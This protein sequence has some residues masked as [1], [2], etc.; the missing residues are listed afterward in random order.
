MR[1]VRR[2]ASPQSTDFA[3][4]KDAKPYLISRLGPYCSYCERK[5]VTMLAVEHLQPKG[6]ASY[7]H[8]EG[9]WEN[10]LLA[11]VNCNSKKRSKNV[12]FAQ[13]FF[14]DRDNTFLA[15]TYL[16][17]GTIEP[18]AQAC[19]FGQKSIADATLSLTGL[20]EPIS[21]ATDE[22]GKQIAIDRVAQRMEAWAKAQETKADIDADPGNEIVRKYAVRLAMETGFFSIWM[23][24]FHSDID[25]RLRL[26]NAFP[27]T[28]ESG[29]FDLATAGP[30]HPA[31]NPDGLPEGGK[32]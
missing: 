17:D 9:R 10:F 24:V 18:S 21:I 4:Y 20:D 7:T 2:D 8:L 22:N 27:G 12:I 15:F 13:L 19:S 11:C 25:I 32:I 31:P 28:Q 5:I 26:I 23:T 3:D 14:P 1:P 6:L 16:P 29:S 30:L